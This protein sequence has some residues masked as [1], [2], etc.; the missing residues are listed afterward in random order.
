MTTQETDYSGCPIS[1]TILD[2]IKPADIVYG[3]LRIEGATGRIVI[4]DGFSR[5]EATQKSAALFVE[6]LQ[7]H[8]GEIVKVSVAKAVA[9]E[10][11]ACAKVAEAY[12]L[13]ENARK[14]PLLMAFVDAQNTT[15]RGI[16]KA[17]RNRTATDKGE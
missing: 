1:G 2:D 5:D 8:L 6:A 16:A 10:R 9:A 15:S 3:Y 13:P 7:G 14:T 12:A 4:G 11:E 17:I